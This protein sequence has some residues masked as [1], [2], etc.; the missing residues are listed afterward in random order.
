MGGVLPYRFYYL[1]GH[2]ADYYAAPSSGSSGGGTAGAIYNNAGVSHYN[3]NAAY[4]D[5]YYNNY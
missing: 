2:M 3:Y 4:G 5:Y 1:A